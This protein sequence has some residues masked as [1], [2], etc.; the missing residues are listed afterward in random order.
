MLDPSS[1]KGIA[2]QQMG[3]TVADFERR[4][5]AAGKLGRERSVLMDPR[6]PS[7]AQAA[8]GDNWHTP[9]T[10]AQKRMIMR[11][12]GL[13]YVHNHPLTPGVPP[14][15]RVGGGEADFLQPL[16]PTDLD[17]F[18]RMPSVD[19]MSAVQ[20]AND[21]WSIA[22]RPPGLMARS[23]LSQ[24]QD[25]DLGAKLPRDGGGA[26]LS[27]FDLASDLA[28][29]AVLSDMIGS[30]NIDDVVMAARMIDRADPNAA[31]NARTASGMGVLRAMDETGLMRTDASVPADPAAAKELQRM[32]D[33]ATEGALSYIEPRLKS[34]GLP[35]R[36]QLLATIGV[37]GAVA[38]E[39]AQS[40][41][42]AEAD[43]DP[44]LAPMP[45]RGQRA[46]APAQQAAR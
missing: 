7:T 36:I 12:R 21:A 25:P 1:V 42:D 41:D 44:M 2:I 28:S 30:A 45:F 15:M 40:Y 31:Q 29:G 34:L 20:G 9:I 43:G 18:A 13:D 32:I 11:E 19:T 14:T 5:V 17:W 10:E 26:P 24:F 16:S 3:D 46:A 37:T 22:Q 39:L 38:Q 35:A 23:R 8:E 4:D 33:L 27:R 6:N